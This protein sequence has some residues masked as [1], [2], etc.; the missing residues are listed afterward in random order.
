MGTIGIGLYIDLSSVSLFRETEL[1]N[2]TVDLALPCT[3]DLAKR[4]I[5]YFRCWLHLGV[6]IV[7][8]KVQP[9]MITVS[10][11]GR[12]QGIFWKAS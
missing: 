11:N 6:E 5:L 4:M 10:P 2:S 9:I 12:C 8:F 1:P 7:D 3:S